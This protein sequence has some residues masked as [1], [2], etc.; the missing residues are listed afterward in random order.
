MNKQESQN[1]NPTT[2][3][4]QIF[5]YDEKT[6]KY[7]VFEPFHDVRQALRAIAAK[8]RDTIQS[9]EAI[10]DE[11]DEKLKMIQEMQHGSN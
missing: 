11:V 10:H 3:P 2:E 8:Q 5:W 9:D 4:F 7:H 6:G 1:N